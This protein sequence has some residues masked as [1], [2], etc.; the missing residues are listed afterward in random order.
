MYV[1]MGARFIL[2]LFWSNFGFISSVF[3]VCLKSIR[4][5]FDRVYA[6]KIPSISTQENNTFFQQKTNDIFRGQ[7]NTKKKWNLLVLLYIEQEQD[8]KIFQ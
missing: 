6:H 5:F 1:F 4:Q 3:W 2:G 7:M 8:T